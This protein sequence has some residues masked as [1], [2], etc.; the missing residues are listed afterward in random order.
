[1]IL[2][3]QPDE[4]IS[5]YVARSY[6][7][8]DDCHATQWLES[9]QKSE[10][11]TRFVLP[12]AAAHGWPSVYGYNRLLH[13]HTLYPLQSLL[14]HDRD[15]SYSG[16]DFWEERIWPPTARLLSF[17]PTCV[18][19]DHERIGFSYWRR[20][21]PSGNLICAE[22]NVIRLT[23]CPYCQNPFFNNGSHMEV[24]WKGCCGFS[25][26]NIPPTANEDPA[27]LRQAKFYRDIL[28]SKH[29]ISTDVV[30]ELIRIKLAEADALISNKI[31]GRRRNPY[32]LEWLSELLERYRRQNIFYELSKYSYE[33]LH[34][35][36]ELYDDFDSLVADVSSKSEELRPINSLWD[37]YMVAK[38]S[39]GQFISEDYRYGVGRW[40][41]SYSTCGVNDGVFR[42]GR[43][44]I[45]D[46]C[47]MPLVGNVRWQL[48]QYVDSAAPNVPRLSASAYEE[49]LKEQRSWP[50][51][52]SP[53][54][55]N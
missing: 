8:N 18:K 17:C 45:F 1:M 53:T 37:T 25:L 52:N 55:A 30:L 38:T 23:V 47:Q 49:F 20:D 3:L 34:Y 11:L 35:A 28:K 46:C 14:K 15:L 19:E 29:H 10:N 51:V 22:H 27:A 9:V 7:L 12:V 41:V 4:L 31:R 2:R 40:S 43:T 44:V 16:S 5:S 24:M 54:R 26:A 42:D 33:L 36:M 13:D 21:F 39:A 6:F 32:W 48:K 50:R